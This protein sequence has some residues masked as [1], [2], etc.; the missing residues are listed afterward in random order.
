MSRRVG[1]RCGQDEWGGD[2]IAS[3]D[4]ML[5]R[6]VERRWRPRPRVG[7][8][9]HVNE[10]SDPRTDFYPTEVYPHKIEK[11]FGWRGICVEPRPAEGAFAGRNCALVQRPLSGESMRAVRFFGT[12][13]TQLQHINRY[14]IDSPNDTGEVLQTLSVR[15]LPTP[16]C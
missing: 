9:S 1:R 16:I 6:R 8:G 14:Q 2:V 7:G 3:C 4:E 15:D 5:F 10:L 12:R 13:G 11:E